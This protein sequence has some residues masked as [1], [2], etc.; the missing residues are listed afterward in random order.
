MDLDPSI[1]V[2]FDPS[3]PGAAVAVSV[4]KMMMETAAENICCFRARYQPP[5]YR[6]GV[7]D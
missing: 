4:L 7:V 3:G 6:P 1:G 5:N 2:E